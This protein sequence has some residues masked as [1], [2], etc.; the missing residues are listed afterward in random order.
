MDWP[1]PTDFITS[2]MIWCLPRGQR[3]F[4]T[5]PGISVSNEQ[6]RHPKTQEKNLSP[7]SRKAARQILTLA[8]AASHGFVD[9]SG[10]SAWY[11][12]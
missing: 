12:R 6:H 8:W 9:I 4:T 7:I 1:P 3:A 5:K 2:K 10:G 11:L